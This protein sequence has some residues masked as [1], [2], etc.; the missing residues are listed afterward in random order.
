MLFCFTW[1]TSLSGCGGRLK[2]GGFMCRAGNS[3]ADDLTVGVTKARFIGWSYI[4][5]CFVFVYINN[6]GKLVTS[7]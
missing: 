4:D 6:L 5:F 3:S 7:S 1:F 2:N